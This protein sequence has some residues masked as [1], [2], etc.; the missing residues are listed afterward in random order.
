[1]IVGEAFNLLVLGGAASEPAQASGLGWPQHR[2]LEEVFVYFDDADRLLDLHANA[3]VDHEADEALTVDED[4]PRAQILRVGTRGVC[5]GAAGDEHALVGIV[6]HERT[7]E[8]LVVV[9]QTQ[10]S[11]KTG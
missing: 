5:E 11:T 10:V 2:L 4:D 1:M 3:V 7:G 9:L 6:T 8:C